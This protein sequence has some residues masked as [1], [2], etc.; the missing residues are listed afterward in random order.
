MN[1]TENTAENLGQNAPLGNIANLRTP[2]VGEGENNQKWEDRQEV[3]ARQR[4]F[5]LQARARWLLRGYRRKNK[6]GENAPYRVNNCLLALGWKSEGYAMISKLRLLK[7]SDIDVRAVYR[8]LQ[9]CASVW[10]CPIC[11]AR[12]ANERR[13]G[14]RL[15]VERAEKIGY[16]VVLVTY[17]ARHDRYTDLKRQLEAMTKAHEAVWRG[18]PAERLRERSGWLGVIRTLECTHSRLN[19]WHPH[20]HALIFMKADTDVKWFEEM[21]RARWE[22]CAAKYG[23][24][25][26]VHGFDLIDSSTWVA[27]YIAKWG[28]EPKWREADEL[29]R[30]HTKRGRLRRDRDEHYSPWQLLDFA[31]NEDGEAGDLW[32]E[33]ALTYYG[34]KQLHWSRGLREA[35]GMKKEMSDEEIVEKDM[36]ETMKMLDVYITGDDWNWVKGNDLRLELLEL[37]EQYDADEI[38][39]QCR[40]K[41]NFVPLVDSGETVELQDTDDLE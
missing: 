40:E 15:A 20:I 12:I 5:R 35:L 30:W 22:L 24:T 27:D 34:R 14:I 3:V 6:K 1:Q 32:R 37:V 31:D 2:P 33:Y 28:H 39:E 4:R 11:A 26:N 19:G 13:E 9:Q 16:R 23:L 10:H 38:I 41:Y 18:A 29:A 17:T 7:G 21:L 25:M 36:E 8:L